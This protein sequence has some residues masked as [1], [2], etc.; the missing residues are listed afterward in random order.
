MARND[1]NIDGRFWITKDGKTIAGKGRIELLKKVKDVGSITQAA[2]EMKMSYKAAWDSIDIMNKM[3]DKPIVKSVKVGKQGGGTYLTE[4]GEAFISLY[5]KY[6]EVFNKTLKFMENNPYGDKMIGITNFKSS[7][8]NTFYGEVIDVNIGAVSAIIKVKVDNDFI[9]TSSIL[10]GTVD[11]L[12]LSIGSKVCCLINSTQIILLPKNE[13]LSISSTNVYSGI[14]KTVTKG[15]VNSEI[16]LS[17]QNDRV[18]N[19]FMTNE[20]VENMKLAY[21]MEV[22]A[23]FSE[24]SVI[25]VAYD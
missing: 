17:L 1:K 4:E 21:G 19:I 11:K 14:I 20:S 18:L 10:N 24:S 23:V 16:C 12:D 5:E 22:S 15:A 2:K 13:N 9:I 3:L 8:D 7:A 6:T 25:I